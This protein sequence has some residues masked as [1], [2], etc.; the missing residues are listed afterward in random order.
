MPFYTL[1]LDVTM[2][3]II[4]PVNRLL[5]LKINVIDMQNHK[6]KKSLRE[7]CQLKS[8]NLVRSVG[9]KLVLVHLVH[10]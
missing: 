4:N 1:Q 8:P 10:N 9:K 7:I 6:H 5:F 3:Y 2:P